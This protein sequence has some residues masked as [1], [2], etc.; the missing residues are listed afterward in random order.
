MKRDGGPD[1]MLTIRSPILSYEIH[2]HT[3]LP[4]SVLSSLSVSLPHTPTHTCITHVP[5]WLSISVSALLSCS[6][7][8]AP[9][10]YPG[11]WYQP[12]TYGYYR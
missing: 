2:T 6:W 1:R 8:L 11:V 5:K 9:K 10:F 3:L 7:Q 4:L 12:K